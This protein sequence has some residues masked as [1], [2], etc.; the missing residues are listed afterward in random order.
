MKNGERDITE[1]LDKQQ[2]VLDNRRRKNR[3]GVV[4]HGAK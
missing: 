4:E 1:K 2:L 3:E